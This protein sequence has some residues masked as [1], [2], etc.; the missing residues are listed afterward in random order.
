MPLSDRNGPL[1][2]AFVTKA[3][4]KA[5]LANVWTHDITE[6]LR[7]RRVGEAK[8]RGLEDYNVGTYP[9]ELLIKK[10]TGLKGVIAGALILGSGIAGGIALTDYFNSKETVTTKII[11]NTKV[12]DTDIEMEI[13]PPE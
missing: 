8:E 9:S 7:L 2:K 10:G 1:T 12:F 4:A 13:I 6:R 5:L 11:D 3:K